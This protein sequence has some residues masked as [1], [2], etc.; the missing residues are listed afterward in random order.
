MI[1]WESGRS[2]EQRHKHNTITNSRGQEVCSSCNQIVI[3]PITD[4]DDPR[5]QN[6][7]LMRSPHHEL[8]R[9]AFSMPLP[10]MLITL[11]NESQGDFPAAPYIIII[12]KEHERR[13]DIHEQLMYDLSRMTQF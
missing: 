1:Q 6:A 2:T 9:P 10:E 8:D 3:K 5:L 13:G 4:S 11:Y 12:M 7:G